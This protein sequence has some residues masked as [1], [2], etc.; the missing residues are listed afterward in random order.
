MTLRGPE[1][2]HAGDR[3]SS[4][5]RWLVGCAKPAGLVLGWWLQS[6]C[7][8]SL[9]VHVSLYYFL[10]LLLLIIKFDHGAYGQRRTAARYL[11]AVLQSR[12][13]SARTRGRCHSQPQARSRVDDFVVAN[14]I[15]KAG[16]CATI[17]L[18]AGRL[19]RTFCFPVCRRI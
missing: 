2:A 9:F 12:G 18:R 8:A 14:C 15:R 13:E 4:G 5:L 3:Q 7:I 1:H 16:Q 19:R 11:A 10:F 17:V 6:P